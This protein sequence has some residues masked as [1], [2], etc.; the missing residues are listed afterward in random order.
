MPTTRIAGAFQQ[1]TSAILG[2]KNQE[3]FLEPASGEPPRGNPLN[4]QNV[5]SPQTLFFLCV[6]G[7]FCIFC[8]SPVS[9]PNRWSWL[10]T[11]NMTGRRFHRTTEA[12][13]RRP[14][15]SKSPFASRPIYISIEKG[16]RGARARYDTVRL[17]FI[18]IVRSPGRPFISASETIRRTGFVVTGLRRWPGKSWT[19]KELVH[20]N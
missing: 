13:P 6:R 10:S 9:G 12:I 18:S 5:E 14:W 17:P 20:S 11:P 16:M 2:R 4:C 3:M 1:E 19:E 7:A 15:K 8:I